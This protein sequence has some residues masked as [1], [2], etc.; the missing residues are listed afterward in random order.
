MHRVVRDNL[1]AF[2][3]VAAVLAVGFVIGLVEGPV[4]PVAQSLQRIALSGFRSAS[5]PK[6]YRVLPL[7]DT[8]SDGAGTAGVGLHVMV[9]ARAAHTQKRARSSTVQAHYMRAGT[10][11]AAVRD[12]SVSACLYFFECPPSSLRT[13][14]N[15]PTES[16][17]P[18]RVRGRQARTAQPA[19]PPPP[20]ART[21]RS[22]CASRTSRSP[23]ASP[24][25][26]APVPPGTR[27]LRA[28]RSEALRLGGKW[29]VPR[30][31]KG[32]SGG[33]F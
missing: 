17:A 23:R 7:R 9:S 6:V 33:V 1:E 20:P 22:H 21:S 30:R 14:A 27:R 3:S 8:L 31:L 10:L 5:G 19:S 2:F 24:P 25:S 28:S 32:R 18:T 15:P 29:G 16:P 4:A 11:L 12:V 26:C 13:R